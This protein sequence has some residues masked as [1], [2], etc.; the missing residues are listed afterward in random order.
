MI[1]V[2]IQ[3][4]KGSVRD[5]QAGA[6]SVATKS[7]DRIEDGGVF[8]GSGLYVGEFVPVRLCACVV[9]SR[10]Q[11]ELMEAHIVAVPGQKLS[12]PVDEITL[13]DVGPLK[14]VPKVD[15]A[16]DTE[17]LGLFL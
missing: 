6:G 7:G 16:V 8:H 11:E 5:A 9:A 12:T 13:D 2:K 14:I 10:L 4:L 3:V 17:L 15:V 1:D